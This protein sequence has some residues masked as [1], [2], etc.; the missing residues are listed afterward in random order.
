M[1]ANPFSFRFYETKR[2]PNRGLFIVRT[3]AR[4]FEKPWKQDLRRAIRF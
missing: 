4:W 1:T 2:A 3:Q